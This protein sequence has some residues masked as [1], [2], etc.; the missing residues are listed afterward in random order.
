METETREFELEMEKKLEEYRSKIEV[1]VNNE[2]NRLSDKKLDDENDGNLS[3]A[4][5]MMESINVDILHILRD[6]DDLM[7]YI[8][9]LKKL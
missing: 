3:G 5:T 6:F 1:I 7:Y 9:I 2:Y 8:D 4:L